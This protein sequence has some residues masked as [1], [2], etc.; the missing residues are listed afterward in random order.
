MR[1]KITFA[2]HI[3]YSLLPPSHDGKPSATLRRQA[4]PRRPPPCL[5][6]ILVLINLKTY[7]QDSPTRGLP[8]MIRFICLI[9][10]GVLAA[11]AFCF[12]AMA[13][14]PTLIYPGKTWRMSKNP[15]LLGWSMKKL[16]A[17]KAY[18]KQ[19]GSAAVMI[20]ENGMVVDS[21]GEIERKY[22]LHS[23]RKPLI[24]A[25]IGIH[26]AKGRIDLSKTMTELGIDDNK[27]SLTRIEKQATIADLIKA[28]S[29]IYHPALGE[30]PG[31]KA[32][33]PERHSHLPG[34]FYYYN[35]WDFNAIGTIF[36]QETGANIF[37]EFSRRIATPLQM[38][39]FKVNDG[40]YNTGP[41]SIHPYYGFRMSARDLARFGLLYLRKGRWKNKQIYRAHT[42]GQFNSGGCCG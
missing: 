17:A 30:A 23:M 18:S 10:A 19:I 21:W 13:A 2:N 9:T 8:P 41:E 33:R 3:G 12:P 7:S 40:W 32:M 29:G 42:P 27:P 28:R 4:C 35:N 38:K 34:T 24:S 37:E 6:I 39:D 36:E 1:K 22:Q 14:D 26:T 25:L 11:C 15:E 20:V 31:M 5:R 16:T